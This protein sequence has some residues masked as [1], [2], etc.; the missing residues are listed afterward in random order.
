MG[1]KV[2]IPHQGRQVYDKAQRWGSVVSLTEG[3]LDFGDCQQ[4]TEV[5]QDRLEGSSQED[6]IVLGGHIVPMI[7]AVGLFSAKHGRVNLL[8]FDHSSEE[9]QEIQIQYDT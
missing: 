5:M 9:Y 4:I 7:L 2:Y 3:W 8:R 6:L 1:R